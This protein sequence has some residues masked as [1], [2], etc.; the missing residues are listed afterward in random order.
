MKQTGVEEWQAA[1]KGGKSDD[2]EY[3]QRIEPL[4]PRR[5]PVWTALVSDRQIVLMTTQ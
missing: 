1:K 2:I 5:E 4:G 3:I